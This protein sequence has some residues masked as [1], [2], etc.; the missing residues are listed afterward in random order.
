MLY[1]EFDLTG[2]KTYP[3]DS[4]QSKVR[5][6]H[7]AT[8]WD[9]ASGMPGWLAS[10][11]NLLASADFRAVVAALRAARASNR[12]IVWGLGAH[13]IKAGLSPVLID[14]MERGFV[15]AIAISKSPFRAR[16][17]RKSTPLSVRASSAWPKKPD[18]I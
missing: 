9:P 7:F 4:R 2:V 6:D 13:V 8:P 18:G 17:P 5:H 1:E 3:L 11:P 14:L 12:A 15:S 10:L 16:R